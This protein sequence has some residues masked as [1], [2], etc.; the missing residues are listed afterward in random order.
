M[1][2]RLNETSKS[3]DEDPRPTAA[4]QRQPGK[5]VVHPPVD[6]RN[7]IGGPA[8]PVAGSKRSG[9]DSRADAV[10][11]EPSKRKKPNATAPRIEV[12]PESEPSRK[13]PPPL[14]GGVIEEIAT[15]PPATTVPAASGSGT[16]SHP[17][18][19]DSDDEQ[20]RAST[21]NQQRRVLDDDSEE[22]TPPASQPARKGAK[23]KKPTNEKERVDPRA[24]D[25]RGLLE[26]LSHIHAPEYTA[27][28]RDKT[29]D[30]RAHFSEPRA[31][32][33]QK[34]KFRDCNACKRKKAR[35]YWFTDEHST[36][37]RH[38]EASHEAEYTTWCKENDFE[39]KLPKFLKAKKDAEA[40]KEQQSTLDDHLQP[41]PEAYSEE[42]FRQAVLE[43]LAATDQPLE[44]VQ[45]KTFRRIINL[46]CQAQHGVTLPSRKATRTELVNMLN[47]YYIDLAARLKRAKGKI[48]ATCDSWTAENNDSYFAVTG[49]W[50]DEENP[51]KWTLEAALIGF[52]NIHHSH[53]GMRLGQALFKIFERVKIA[54]NIGWVTCDNASN[55]GTMMTEV[56][57]RI[58]LEG[59]VSF[60][61]A[62]RRIRCLAHIIN[63]A[64]QALLKA[65]SEAR[66]RGAGV[67]DEALLVRNVSIK[68][69]SSDL[70][71][72]RFHKIQA[73]RGVTMPRNL[74]RDMVVRWSSTKIMLDRAVEHRKDI[75]QFLRELEREETNAEKQEALGTLHIS[76]NEWKNVEKLLELLSLSDDAQIA[77]SA[78]TYPT[79]FNAVPA[80][81]LL[82]TAW[83]KRLADAN[84]VEFH[85][86]LQLGINKLS[87]YKNQV[88]TAECDAYWVSMV[89]HPE[90]KFGPEFTHFWGDRTADLKKEMETKFKTRF[91]LLH[92]TNGPETQ[93]VVKK[94][95]I[96]RLRADA[97]RPSNAAG[98]TAPTIEP[99]RIEYERFINTQ[100]EVSEGLSLVSW[101]G[102]YASQLPTWASLAADYL[103]I[104]ASSVSS[105]RAFSSAGITV[106]K[107][108]NRLKGDIVEALQVLKCAIRNDLLVREPAP[109]SIVDRDLCPEDSDDDEPELAGIRC[110][111][112]MRIELSDDS[113]DDDEMELDA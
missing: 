96:S 19:L 40:A 39:S 1:G 90:Y 30:I 47:K 38:M 51:G 28:A 2:K 75:N 70:R 46:A 44:A 68:E 18:E 76:A 53:N 80:L 98:S 87:D 3:D 8:K 73:D 25:D 61:S 64:T 60:D 88:Q 97:A 27:S 94:S 95:G 31:V 15:N 34:G 43:W 62:Q 100:Y 12:F 57:N 102:I 5:R 56:A 86:A 79:L 101:W 108:R 63:L 99:W 42:V 103:A 59:D 9:A 106:T 49:H 32:S 54:E 67:R 82:L 14:S 17:M 13:S 55:N 107:R 23:A 109:S 22:D 72:T 104:M 58:Q 10:A 65:R 50:I 84:F 24:V 33:G 20:P 89:I 21:R 83:E 16:Q 36:L 69:R 105:E 35:K 11:N 85:A 113:E 81:T 91:D 29:R 48:S 74:L 71:I 92:K 78:E 110:L 77:F 112:E 6:N 41:M 45:H 7:S 52:V 93:P 111:P 4:M 37:R 66:F 26:D